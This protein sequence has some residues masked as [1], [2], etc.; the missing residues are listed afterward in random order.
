MI[1]CGNVGQ[2]LSVFKPADMNTNGHRY[3][4]AKA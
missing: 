2:S 3:A 1:N 4:E